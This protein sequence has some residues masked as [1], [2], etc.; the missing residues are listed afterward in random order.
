[1]RCFVA[2]CTGDN[3]VQVDVAELGRTAYE[4]ISGKVFFETDSTVDRLT[5][6]MIL[7]GPCLADHC[8]GHIAFRD[9]HAGTHQPESTCALK[10]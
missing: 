2:T 7:V 6:Q 3:I 1:M 10:A 9:N 8:H 5:G 4:K